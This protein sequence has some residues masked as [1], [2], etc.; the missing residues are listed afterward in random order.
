MVNIQMDGPTGRIIHLF[1]DHIPQFF[2]TSL[3]ELLPGPF[4]MSAL[5]AEVYGP[6]ADECMNVSGH[7]F[8]LKLSI[9]SLACSYFALPCPIFLSDSQ[10]DLETYMNFMR[11]KIKPEFTFLLFLRY[12]TSRPALPAFVSFQESP[13]NLTT[14][15][16]DA[17]CID[18]ML[19]S[20]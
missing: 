8:L 4:L 19:L 1:P 20:N 10:N 2:P 13:L 9:F 11:K 15:L 5:Q 3:A 6:I 17:N 14:V 7:V 12:D 18:L 16:A